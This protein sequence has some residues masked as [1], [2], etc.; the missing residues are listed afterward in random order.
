MEPA[1]PL[2]SFLWVPCGWI[3]EVA[4]IMARSCSHIGRYALVTWNYSEFKFSRFLNSYLELLPREIWQS[5]H[6]WCATLHPSTQKGM[7]Q[8]PKSHPI[9]QRRTH[10]PTVISP[11]SVVTIDCT[12]LLHEWQKHLVGCLPKRTW[13]CLTSP[14]AGTTCAGTTSPWT[15]TG[16]VGTGV[17]S[18]RWITSDF[19]AGSLSGI[20]TTVA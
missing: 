19:T 8:Q 2:L 11:G 3:F 13:V 14:A 12:S 7:R 1:L 5:G 6:R 17:A 20:L 16:C 4:L 15:G 9:Q 18:A 10:A